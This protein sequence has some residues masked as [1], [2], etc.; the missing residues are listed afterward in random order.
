[1][2][3]DNSVLTQISQYNNYNI[4]LAGRHVYCQFS[5]V[6]LVQSILLTLI[7]K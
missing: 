4:T 5:I 7:Y 3:L 6:V 2:T 1:M